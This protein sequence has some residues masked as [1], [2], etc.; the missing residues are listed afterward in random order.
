MK[1][2]KTIGDVCL[3]YFTLNGARYKIVT[4]ETIF[5][6]EPAYNSVTVCIVSPEGQGYYGGA[7]ANKTNA[8]E[9]AID[10]ALQ[11]MHFAG[12]KC[13]IDSETISK[14]LDRID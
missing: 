2:I 7:D 6:N 13:D 3:G 5:N 9:A 4:Y 14:T 1:P 11:I 12:V 8:V 10:R